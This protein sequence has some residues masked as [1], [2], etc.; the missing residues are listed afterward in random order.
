MT[1]LFVF[2]VRTRTKVA[3]SETGT[4]DSY[5]F[6]LDWSP[7]GKRIAY[8]RVARDLRRY[9]LFEAD[10]ATGASVR[11]LEEVAER[12]VVK[13]PRPP[14]TFHYLPDGRRFLWLSDRDGYAGYYLY[15]RAGRPP[16]KVS[17]QGYEVTLVAIEKSGEALILSGAPNPARPYDKRLL[18]W[19]FGGRKA[20]FLSDESGM[21]EAQLSPSGQIPPRQASR[22][23][24]SSDDRDPSRR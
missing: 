7:D 21:H 4:T 13:W 22:R 10:A 2:D 3:L 18:R 17:P 19:Q 23:R 5:L 24:S 8:V 20:V 14:K 1:T 16:R 9:E 12:G 6:F 15:P 11:L